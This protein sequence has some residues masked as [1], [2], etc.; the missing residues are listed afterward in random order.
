MQ[1][2]SD[3]AVGTCYNDT[4]GKYTYVFCTNGTGAAQSDAAGNSIILGT[5]LGWSNARKNAG[6]G[7]GTP[8]TV[9]GWTY[10]R[11]AYASYHCGAATGI[12][13]VT[14]TREWSWRLEHSLV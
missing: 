8:C 6:F 12:R 5:Y 14:E 13:Q 10:P 4:L 11:S 3:D 2:V 1:A 7:N 9:N